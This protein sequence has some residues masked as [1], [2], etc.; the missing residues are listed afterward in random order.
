MN[1]PQAATDKVKAM[2]TEQ[3]IDAFEL[4]TVMTKTV[5]L[6]M[7]RG[8]IMDELEARDRNA[9]DAFLD[10]NEDSPRKFYN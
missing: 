2:T 6:S 8:W 4:T 9:F 10:S 3:L 1:T 7:A 5:E